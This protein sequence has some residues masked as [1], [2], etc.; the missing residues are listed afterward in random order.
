[1]TDGL[2]LDGR[3]GCCASA[4]VVLLVYGGLLGLTVLRSSR[5]APTGFIPQQDKG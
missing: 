2:R 3:H 4:S 1:M 5:S